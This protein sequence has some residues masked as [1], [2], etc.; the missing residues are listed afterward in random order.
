M[1]TERERYALKEAL[2][3]LIANGIEPPRLIAAD[4][5]AL[6]TALTKIEKGTVS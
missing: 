2:R 4:L 5:E 1:L 3:Y 6:R